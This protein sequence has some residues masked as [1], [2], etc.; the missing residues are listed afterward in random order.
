[1]DLNH[2]LRIDSPPPLT[3]KSNFDKMRDMKMWERSNCVTIMK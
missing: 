1:M 2:V 3:D